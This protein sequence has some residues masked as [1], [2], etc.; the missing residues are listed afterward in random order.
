MKS[1]IRII[2]LKSKY[3]IPL[4]ICCLFNGCI[5]T[6]TSDLARAKGVEHTQEQ[7]ITKQGQSLTDILSLFIASQTGVSTS[8]LLGIT[9]G[10]TINFIDRKFEKIE[11]Y[12]EE[13]YKLNQELL[14]LGKELENLK[15][16]YQ[17]LQKALENLQ[18]IKESKRIELKALNRKYSNKVNLYDGKLDVLKDYI[19]NSNKI[20]KPELL[21]NQIEEYRNDLHQL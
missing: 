16:E 9:N 6:K 11:Q 19:V 12:K 14:A 5:S 3:L 20:V 7:R 13:E 1:T 17:I 10:S 15:I 21:L 8:L 4:T 2:S 18:D